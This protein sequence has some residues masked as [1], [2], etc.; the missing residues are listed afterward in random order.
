MINKKIRRNLEEIERIKEEK[1]ELKREEEEEL[2]RRSERRSEMKA[3]KKEEGEK[4]KKEKEE[5]DEKEK[6][7]KEEEEERNKEESKEEKKINP[8]V[9]HVNVDSAETIW[10]Q[11][12]EDLMKASNNSD[13]KLK[14]GLVKLVD[15]EH[16]VIK[17]RRSFLEWGTRHEDID[18]Q[19]PRV[20]IPMTTE[21]LEAIDRKLLGGQDY[22]P[23]FI[24]NMAK[25]ETFE[26]GYADLLQAEE[27]TKSVVFSVITSYTRGNTSQSKDCLNRLFLTPLEIRWLN[28]MVNTRMEEEKKDV[29][30]PI[31]SHI[32]QY[33]PHLFEEWVERKR[34]LEKRRVTSLK[35]L[36]RKF[37][38]KRIN[39]NISPYI[40]ACPCVNWV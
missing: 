13:P 20:I 17:M 10:R 21:C 28:L 37:I 7:I 24:P 39:P 30:W 18:P 38:Q 29:I 14:A 22:T 32:G 25:V 40:K 5:K 19:G 11:I 6:K 36:T 33:H 26:E 31:D 16:P 8:G 35:D 12:W 3:K 27:D 4:E 9:W 34:K 2:R 1:R 23:R 15:P